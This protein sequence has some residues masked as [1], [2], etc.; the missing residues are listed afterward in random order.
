V[1]F[2]F[3]LL[4]LSPRWYAEVARAAEAAGF[5]SVWVQEHVVFPA[6]MPHTY[7]YSD[8]G[9]PGI[10]SK[11]PLIDPWIALTTIA[12]A[13]ESVRLASNVY[14]LPL[15][16]PFVTARAAV[17]LDRVSGGRLSL[18]VGV[19]WL[20]QEYEAMQ[21]EWEGRGRRM[22]EIID[23]MRRLWSEETIEHQGEFYHFDP[24]CFE[25]KPL[26]KSGIPV[27][28]GGESR[29][30]MRRAARIGD[31]WIMT[32]LGA[33]EE[34]AEKVAAMRA[35]RVE[36]GRVDVPFEITGSVQRDVSIDGLR[37]YQANGVDR[38]IVDAL[39]SRSAQDVVDALHR[40]RDNTAS[41]L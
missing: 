33:A 11:T 40:F 24:V 29:P 10:A 35:L 16:S 28:I 21:V 14:V 6:E 37:A 38:V 23:I 36:H 22:D 25:P 8:D 32:W 2:G 13:T 4:G 39:G 7:P 31:G 12:N 18:G 34:V 1:K 30:A 27:L 15:R 9:N 26:Q 41:K 19:G 5:D 20:Q 17:T 3:S